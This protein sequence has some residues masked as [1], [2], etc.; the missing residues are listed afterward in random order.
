MSL[1]RASTAPNAPDA[2]ADNHHDPSWTL[3]AYDG[4]TERLAEPRAGE[5]ND[6]A[7]TQGR[8]AVVAAVAFSTLALVASGA[9]ATMSW[10]A[11]HQPPGN[12]Q[13]Q[14]TASAPA[15]DVAPAGGQEGGY[16]ATYAQEPLR[17][18]VGCAAAMYVDLDEPR[19]N[20][21]PGRSDLRYDSRCG[22]KIKPTLSLGPG[23]QGGNQVDSSGTDAAGCDRAI[24]TSPLG[25][26][27]DVPAVK[28]AVL[29]VLTAAS[30]APT[31]D[32]G[33]ERPR[34][35]LVEV[36]D[37]AADGTAELRATSWT[38]P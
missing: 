33:G 22:G 25:S 3:P 17:M 16:Q 20:A 23:A 35:V 14:A 13:P 7:R 32:Q 38:V 27:A 11:E 8:G 5:G 24:R 37:V 28:G 29:C 4:P 31:D 36:T 30:G 18:Q 21:E 6:V 34:M 19:A 26:G 2:P 9:A 12:E 15:P 10:R 1:F